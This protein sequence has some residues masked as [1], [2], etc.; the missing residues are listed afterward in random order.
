MKDVAIVVGVVFGLGLLDHVLGSPL[1]LKLLDF[2]YLDRY[3]DLIEK[4]S[5]PAR[6]LLRPQRYW[7]SDH[8]KEYL[9]LCEDY[10][11]PTMDKYQLIREMK[12]AWADGDYL[13][14]YNIMKDMDGNADDQIGREYMIK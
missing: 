10:I 4:Y 14:L 3:G 8:Y 5:D 11:I 12:K 7:V 2:L 6:D 13:S 1:Y 9:T